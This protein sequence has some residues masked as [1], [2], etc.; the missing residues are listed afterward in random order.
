MPKASIN[1]PDGTAVS[2]EGTEEQVARLLAIY[3]S[4]SLQGAPARATTKSLKAPSS[5]PL[6]RIANLVDEGFFTKPKALGDVR[7]KLREQG[8]IYK[9][10]NL[11]P[12]LLRLLK[13]KTL[14]R[15]QEEGSWKYV[16]P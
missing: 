11:S 4:S 2:V 15:I 3:K 1:L 6:Q 14:R 8:Y 10:E 13:R 5:G 12:S 16:N 7:E 9:S